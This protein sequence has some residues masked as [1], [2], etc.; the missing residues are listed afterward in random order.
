M[1]LEKAIELTNTI[2]DMAIHHYAPNIDNEVVEQGNPTYMLGDEGR[3]AV[4]IVLQALENSIPKKKI[5]YKIKEL[6]KRYLTKA[7]DIQN[8]TSVTFMYYTGMVEVLQELL[9]DK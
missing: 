9:E 7:E 8:E 1:E 6:K 4:K 3:T 2:A 5:E